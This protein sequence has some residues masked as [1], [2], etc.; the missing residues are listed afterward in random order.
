MDSN[1]LLQRF[2]EVLL[3]IGKDKDMVSVSYTSK[4]QVE[5]WAKNMRCHAT[6]LNTAFNDALR[7]LSSKIV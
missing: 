3:K 7:L 6:E 5:E 1:Q 4:K 2:E